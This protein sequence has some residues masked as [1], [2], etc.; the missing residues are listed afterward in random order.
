M[1][2]PRDYRSYLRSVGRKSVKDMKLRTERKPGDVEIVYRD[3]EYVAHRH[4]EAA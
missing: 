4:E 2:R 3:G 1:P